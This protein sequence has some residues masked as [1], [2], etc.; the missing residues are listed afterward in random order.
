VLQPAAD[1]PSEA[2]LAAE[3][4]AALG[5]AAPPAISVFGLEHGDTVIFAFRGG[6]ADAL[7]RRYVALPAATLEKDLHAMKAAPATAAGAPVGGGSSGGT[8]KWVVPV[9]AVMGVMLFIVAVVLVAKRRALFGAPSVDL[10]HD[11][12]PVNVDGG[13]AS[14]LSSGRISAAGEYQRFDDTK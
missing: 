10:A 3:L 4:Q 6:D 1:V 9:V 8:P 12:G 13:S 11:G 14:E 5:L 7:A 2:Q